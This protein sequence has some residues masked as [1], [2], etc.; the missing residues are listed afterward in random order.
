MPVVVGVPAV[1]RPVRPTSALDAADDAVTTLVRDY[2][3]RPVADSAA[4]A[5]RML[6][7]LT[8]LPR[9]RTLSP[10]GRVHAARLSAVLH[11]VRAR[12]RLDG[13]DVFGAATSLGTAGGLT[14]PADRPLAAFI[15]LTRVDVHLA[16]DDPDAALDAAETAR[17]AA[18][19]SKVEPLALAYVVRALARLDGSADA[20]AVLTQCGRVADLVENTDLPETGVGL[21]T[22]SRTAVG[23]ALAEA[24]AHLPNT[25]GAA[26]GVVED[27]LPHADA[28][29]EYPGPIRLSLAGALAGTEAEQAARYALD[30][31]TRCRALGPITAPVVARARRVV[32]AIAD[33]RCRREVADAL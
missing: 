32:D 16:D 1:S 33:P 27:V 22:T 23:A 4:S 24:L 12:T 7:A 21:D 15:A 18:T 26:L 9:T 8:A 14:T 29:R 25:A 5:T 13:G 6:S 11:V 10:G 3:Q 28:G 31:I 2:P 19:G 20:L 17:L 30:G